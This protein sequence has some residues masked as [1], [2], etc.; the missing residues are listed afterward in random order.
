MGGLGGG[1]RMGGWVPVSV[2]SMCREN[3]SVEVILQDMI[4]ELTATFKTAIYQAW[5]CIFTDLG[6]TFHCVT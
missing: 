1:N 2:E 5:R 4:D 3:K 6:N